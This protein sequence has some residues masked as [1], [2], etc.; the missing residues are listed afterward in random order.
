MVGMRRSHFGGGS[1]VADKCHPRRIHPS[2]LCR[3]HGSGADGPLE[4][5]RHDQKLRS[6]R[7]VRRR[8]PPLV[9]HRLHGAGRLRPATPTASPQRPGALAYRPR[10]V[11]A[12]PATERQTRTLRRGRPEPGRWT[13]DTPILKDLHS[14][15]AVLLVMPTLDITGIEDAR[16]LAPGE[17]NYF[18]AAWRAQT[19]VAARIGKTMPRQ[20]MAVSVNSPYG[21]SQDLLH[22]HVDCLTPRSVAALT[23]DL[24]GIGPRWSRAPFTFEG[25]PYYADPARRRPAGGGPLPG[26]GRTTC[27]G[28]APRTWPPCGRWSWS[29][30]Y[31]RGRQA[32][33]R[34]ARGRAPTLRTATSPRA[35]NWQDHECAIAHG[36]VMDDARIPRGI[37]AVCGIEIWNQIRL[38][39]GSAKA[40]A[41]SA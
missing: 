22:L 26:P 30:R 12:R 36:G 25:H 41:A 29:A 9:R 18:A 37:K 3:Y 16:L 8:A 5:C 6:R 24:P 17:P 10:P 33:V 35:R 1:D 40:G 13:A 34:V 2:M 14:A 11:H 21:R 19:Y 31:V 23:A 7:V 32:G 28:A 15:E 27:P 39:T 38:A 4:G 20:D